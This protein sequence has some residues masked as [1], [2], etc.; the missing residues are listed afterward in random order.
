MWLGD[1]TELAVHDVDMGSGFFIPWGSG[2]TT[3]PVEMKAI[4]IFGKL[5]GEQYE[6]PFV[7]TWTLQEDQPLEV[8]RG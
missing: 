3:T 5:S 1:E 8:R 7:G 2:K 6:K 4:R